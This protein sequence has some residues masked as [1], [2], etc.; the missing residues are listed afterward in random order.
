[1]R[2][3]LS[4]LLFLCAIIGLNAQT[5]SS[6]SI[7]FESGIGGIDGDLNPQLYL[8]QNMYGNE[9]YDQ[10]SYYDD[11]FN[12]TFCFVGIRPELSFLKERLRISSGLRFKM[13]RGTIDGKDWNNT[14]QPYFFLRHQGED[15][16]DFYRV[17]SLKETA[18]HLSVPLDASF[19]LFKMFGKIH[20]YIKGGLE[21]GATVYKKTHIHFLNP[22]MKKYEKEVLNGI[23]Y[24]QNSFYSAAYFGYGARVKLR[25]EMNFDLGINYSLGYFTKKNYNLYVDNYFIEAYLSV[26]LPKKMF[27][28]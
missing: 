20:I 9:L 17:R 5:N 21:A 7:G 22:E 13:T 16:L 11:T 23:D 15:R 28:K 3:S 14:N 27:H 4:G 24:N 10:H 19:E 18:N 8:S 1:M 12:S 2:K 26:S 6:I 25:N